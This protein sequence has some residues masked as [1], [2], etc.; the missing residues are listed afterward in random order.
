M[1]STLFYPVYLVLAVI[2][3][4]IFIPKKHYKEYFIY[5]FLIGGLGDFMAV[6]LFQNILH[7]IWFKNLGIFNINGQHILSPCSWTVTVMLFL[8]FLP[9]RRFFMYF[10]ILTYAG[11]SVSYGIL[12]KNVGLFDFRPLLYPYFSFLIFLSWW[13]FAAWFFLK[14]S[15]LAKTDTSYR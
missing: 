12:V 5:G 8:R 13:C 14:T 6:S 9:D 2:L 1:V 7:I 4:L 3:T 10:Y 15:S 11:F